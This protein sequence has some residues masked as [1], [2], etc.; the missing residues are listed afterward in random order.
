MI[1]ALYNLAQISF[2][3][4]APKMF[5]GPLPA[6]YTLLQMHFHWGEQDS[7]GS[8]HSNSGNL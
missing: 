7:E 3:G 4:D 2:N 6:E 8:E 5:G 1:I